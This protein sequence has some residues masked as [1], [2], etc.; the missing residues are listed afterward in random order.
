MAEKKKKESFKDQ[1]KMETQELCEAAIKNGWIAGL[2]SLVL[3][4]I[5]STAGF[6]TQSDNETLNYFLDP[7]LM[8]DVVL[9][10]ILTLFIYKKSRTAATLMFIYFV[11]SKFS[12][13]YDLGTVQGLPMA[14]IFMYFY[15]NAMR[16][17]FI[18]HS[19]YKNQDTEL[20]LEA[21]I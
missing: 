6:F 10:A 13:W 18:W 7:W 16:G 2:I 14:L 19:K 5:F 4:L 11:I 21:E 17:T 3:T 8:I 20:S 12:Q 1:M 9:I 15:F